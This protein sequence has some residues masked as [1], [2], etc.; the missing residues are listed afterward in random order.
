MSLLATRS[1]TAEFLVI[2]LIF[3]LVL[4]ATY[5]VTRWTA[6]YQKNRGT[7]ANIE[8]LDAAQL[9]NNKYVQIVRIGQTYYALAVCKDTV[10][11]LGEI[12][13][14]QLKDYSNADAGTSFREIFSKVS[15]F[16][17]NSGSKDEADEESSTKM[18]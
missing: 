12:P 4:I 6:N 14:E 17:K 16:Q 13:G 5:F 7:N 9:S 1:S 18:E 15:G 8:L 11:M 10:T 3:V 2:L